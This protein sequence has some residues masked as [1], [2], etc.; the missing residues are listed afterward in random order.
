MHIDNYKFALA[1][2]VLKGLKGRDIVGRYDFTLYGYTNGREQ[3]YTVSGNYPCNVAV[4][5]AEN[6]ASD[7]IVV[8]VRPGWS[9]FEDTL[10][11]SE[12]DERKYFASTTR[13]ISEAVKYIADELNAK[14]DF[15]GN[16][17]D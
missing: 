14:R 8:Y 15:D 3:G 12:Y 10:K 16:K 7:D 9:L 11:Q 13:G 2:K 4:S 1:N 17:R 6:R 5:F